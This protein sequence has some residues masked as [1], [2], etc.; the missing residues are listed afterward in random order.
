MFYSS[1]PNYGTVNNHLVGLI[2]N[3]HLEISR[4]LQQSGIQFR[5]AQTLT[6]TNHLEVENVVERSMKENNFINT[7]V[8]NAIAQSAHMMWG[9]TQNSTYGYEWNVRRRPGNPRHTTYQST[10]E[11]LHMNRTSFNSPTRMLKSVES[12]QDFEL[13]SIPNQ[14]HLIG[15]RQFVGSPEK[16]V[17]GITE[18]MV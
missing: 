1:S 16:N 14:S 15:G 13:N 5:G 12:R 17:S 4:F 3:N 11:D 9:N 18:V 7:S 6:T 10:E 8:A 2:S